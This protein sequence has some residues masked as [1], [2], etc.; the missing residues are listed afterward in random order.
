MYSSSTSPLLFFLVAGLF[1]FCAVCAEALLLCLLPVPSKGTKQVT[2]KWM[3]TFL[4]EHSQLEA[5][6]QEADKRRIYA[7]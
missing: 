6:Q 4:G 1:S 7:E 3:V 5:S 2:V